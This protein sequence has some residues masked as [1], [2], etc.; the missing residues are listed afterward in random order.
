[1]SDDRKTCVIQGPF[2]TRS[3]YGDS[4]RDFISHIIDMDEYDVSL[5]STP[6]GNTPMNALEME[7]PRHRRI[8]DHMANPNEKIGT[9]DIFIQIGL[10]GEFQPRGKYNIGYTAGIEATQCSS[11]WVNGCNRMDL[12]IT[13]S[14]HSKKVLQAT[15][16]VYKSTGQE[17]MVDTPVEVIP[18]CIDI[19][20]FK[21]ILAKEV[22]DDVNDIMERVE[23]D[24]N[25]LFVGHWMDRP[26]GADRK[27][28]GLLVKTFCEEFAGEDDAPGLVLKSSG[29]AFSISDA[30][31]ILTQINQIR[32]SVGED[33]PNVYLIHGDLTTEQMNGLYNHPKV[34]A[35]ITLT[36]G[37]G[38]G[39][40]LLEASVSGKPIIASGWSGHMDF[41]NNKEAILIPGEFGK[42]EPE[43]VSPGVLE[44]TAEWYNV[45]VDF[46][47]QSMRHVID[48]YS[49]WERRARQLG[50][51][52]RQNYSYESVFSRTREVMKGYLDNA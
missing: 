20:V 41:L 14:E 35:H 8:V 38:F 13:M 10:P 4:S 46:T 39:R 50:K 12:V 29:P 7:D 11:S 26:L 43:S 1:M 25:F 40:P 21:R 5:I 52:N 23:E 36:K 24:F 32:D 3:G 22:P 9:P 42:I 27:N 45:D 17:I 49:K 33:A 47:K 48:N 51:D 2:T 16:V 30:E 31:R 15:K 6:W 34:K 18:N 37:E 28:V 19:E 44:A